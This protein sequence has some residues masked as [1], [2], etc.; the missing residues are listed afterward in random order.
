MFHQD[1]GA[2]SQLGKIVE[3]VQVPLFGI[4]TDGRGGGQR[5]PAAEYGE[6]GKEPLQGRRLGRLG[7]RQQVIA[8]GQRRTQG[9]VA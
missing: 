2:L 1:Q 4:R 3:G 5:I 7:R 6:P 8:S 9:A